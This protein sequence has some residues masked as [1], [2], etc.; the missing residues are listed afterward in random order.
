MELGA[1]GLILCLQQG[2]P[3]FYLNQVVNEFDGHVPC[4]PFCFLGVFWD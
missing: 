2:F 1:E 3:L 4:L